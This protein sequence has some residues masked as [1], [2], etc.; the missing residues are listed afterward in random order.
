MKGRGAGPWHRQLPVAL[1]R[2]AW[3]ALAACACGGGESGAAATDSLFVEVMARLHRAPAE[4]RAEGPPVAARQAEDSARAAILTEH[5]LTADSLLRLAERVGSD[6]GRMAELWSAV[7]RR[8]EELG[9]GATEEGPGPGGLQEREA[10]PGGE[11][12]AA[13]R[14]TPEREPG[15]A[16]PG[17]PRPGAVEPRPPGE[18]KPRADPVPPVRIGDSAAIRERLRLLKDRVPGRAGA[19]GPETSPS[20][21]S[22]GEEPEL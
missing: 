8:V 13:S 12:G 15:R 3:L 4:V 1:S 5:G 10:S 20:G 16:L 14:D 17:R 2:A 7:S 11:P 18:A 9:A 19:A 21:N 22:V 6:P